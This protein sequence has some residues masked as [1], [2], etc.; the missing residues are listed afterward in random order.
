MAC[1]HPLVGIP[2]GVNP[3]TGKTH[4][5][6]LPYNE[7]YFTDRYVTGAVAIPCGNCIGCRLDYSRQWAN[8]CMLERKYHDEAWFVTITYS[9][10]AVPTTY[11]VDDSTGEAA[12]IYTLRKRDF[13]LF[14]KVLRR[15]TGQKVRY[16]AAGEYGDKTFRPHYHAIIFGL[17]LDDL[18][19]SEFSPLDGPYKYYKSVT[20]QKCWDVVDS[21]CKEGITPLT[22]GNVLVA[23]CSWETCAY[24]ARYVVKKLKGPEAEFYKLH[25]IEPPFSLMSRKPGIGRQYYDDHPNLYDVEY[26]NVS[27]PEG[28]RK[29]RPPKYFDRLREQVDPDA[30]EQVKA[31]RRSLVET[32]KALLMTRS[33][34]PYK[35]ILA[36][37][38]DALA[39]KVRALKRSVV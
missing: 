22:R 36:V 12:P 18:Q 11:F 25:N 14:M 23:P 39:A 3:G 31:F 20:L 29:F 7:R 32:Q 16:F 37:Q 28:G 4:Y 1:N 21:K 2:D 26:I 34:R 6:I 30:Y 10:E 38:G 9:P 24:V 8:R 17:H 27:T 5:K 19:L 13:Q 15:R 33:D 35:E